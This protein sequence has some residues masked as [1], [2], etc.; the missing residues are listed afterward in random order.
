[1]KQRSGKAGAQNRVAKL[2]ERR[3]RVLDDKWGFGG[4]IRRQ[5]ALFHWCCGHS[6]KDQQGNG[7]LHQDVADDRAQEK[8]LALQQDV[9]S[10]E[11]RDK[12]MFAHC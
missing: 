10:F 4:Q 7:H 3:P 12:K 6:Q 5:E 8:L 2:E 9:P 11:N 1:M